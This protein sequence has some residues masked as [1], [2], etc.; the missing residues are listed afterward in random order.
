MTAVAMKGVSIALAFGAF[1]VRETC[2]RCS[3][4]LDEENEQIADLTPCL[5]TNSTASCLNPRLNILLVL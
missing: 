2:Y 3:P 5:V 4:K 1:D